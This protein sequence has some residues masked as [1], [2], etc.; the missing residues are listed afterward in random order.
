[1]GAHDCIV[2]K[3]PATVQPD[4]VIGR[5]F[6]NSFGCNRVGMRLLSS[7]PCGCLCLSQYHPTLCDYRPVKKMF[8]LLPVWGFWELIL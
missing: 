8:E 4:V 6:W 7:N 5:S 3:D 1:M 2:K